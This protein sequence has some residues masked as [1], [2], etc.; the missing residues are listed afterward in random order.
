MAPSLE[1][2]PSHIS[3]R[4]FVLTIPLVFGSA[5]LSAWVFGTIQQY[6]DNPDSSFTVFQNLL[7][8]SIVII[9]FIF[10]FSLVGLGVGYAWQGVSAK[11][12]ST[13][14]KAY[15]VAFL[16]AVFVGGLIWLSF[17]AERGVIFALGTL[18]GTFSSVVA[19]SITN[20]KQ[21]KRFGAILG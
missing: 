16:L 6:I 21:R 20:E 4:R 13:S 18:A 5:V 10:P 19:S 14:R 11:K 7:F 8:A 12:L 9:F 15:N 17:T 1:F 3:T 2:L